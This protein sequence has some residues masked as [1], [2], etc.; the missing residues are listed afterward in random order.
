MKKTNWSIWMIGCMLSIFIVSCEK[1][2]A[3]IDP[4]LP[5]SSSSTGIPLRNQA[6]IG[7]MLHLDSPTLKSSLYKGSTFLPNNVTMNFVGNFVIGA[8]PIKQATGL[9]CRNGEFWICTS[10]L[11]NYP[12]RLMQFSSTLVLINSVALSNTNITHI[13]YT[14]VG[15]LF[16]LDPVAKRINRITPG[17]GVCI[18]VGPVLSTP[19]GYR[20]SGL[21]NYLNFSTGAQ[22][23]GVGYLD[24]NLATLDGIYGVNLTTMLFPTVVQQKYT[25]FSPLAIQYQANNRGFYAAPSTSFNTWYF[26]TLFTANA[27]PIPFVSPITLSI[28]DISET[29]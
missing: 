16:G 25:P 8:N 15:D 17:T 27:P 11:S 23:I 2:K 20:L 10:S 6:G 29:L 24:N 12:N 18:A 19:P 22:E 5:S 3:T 13:E 14:S 21:A 1:E 4:T 26:N 28:A 7:Y 9:A